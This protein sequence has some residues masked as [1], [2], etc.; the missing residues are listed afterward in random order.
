MPAK[1][2][3]PRNYH[4]QYDIWYQN[5]S[6]KSP[7]APLAEIVKDFVL[8]NQLPSFK[9]KDAAEMRFLELAEAHKVTPKRVLSGVFEPKKVDNFAFYLLGGV[10]NIFG[11][12]DKKFD[13]E[14][15][16]FDHQT[17]CLRECHA[18][19]PAWGGG[20]GNGKRQ[21]RKICIYDAGKVGKRDFFQ[22][23][24][25]PYCNQRVLII[26]RRA[27][28]VLIE[29]KLTGFELRP[30]LDGKKRWS[31]PELEYDYIDKAQEGD[32]QWFQL[33]ILERNCTPIPLTHALQVP[34]R[35]GSR[36]IIAEPCTICKY[37]SGSDLSPYK[38]YQKIHPGSR[39]ANADIQV[40]DWFCFAGSEFF[41]DGLTACV[42]VS[43]RFVELIERN[44]LKGITRGVK[45]FLH[46]AMLI[47]EEI[48]ET[49][50]QD[51]IAS[52]PVAENS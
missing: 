18:D 11:F 42:V 38:M 2:F 28:D 41:V 46:Q 45:P 31:E 15:L 44:K 25:W 13:T 8:A 16:L 3:S 5:G 17:D 1:I 34:V 32:A 48:E 33:T 40:W 30:I 47:K 27:R 36:S 22:P 26:S 21:Q 12:V 10:D 39:F 50:A 20:C 49:L 9:I 6:Y 14:H 19:Q 4:N 23:A 51:Q 7:P 29:A 24:L 35:E 37:N 52:Y 43:S